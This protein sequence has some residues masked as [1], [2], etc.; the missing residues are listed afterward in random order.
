MI[1]QRYNLDDL[2]TQLR[3]NNLSSIKDVDYAILETSGRLSVFKKQGKRSQDFP[4]PLII[5]GQI[6]ND[7]LEL[8]DKDISWVLDN[9]KT[10]LDDIFYGFYKNDNIYIIKKSDLN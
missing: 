6:Q 9:I 10:D 2:L 4:L 7:N 3:E 8:L 1:K 5:E